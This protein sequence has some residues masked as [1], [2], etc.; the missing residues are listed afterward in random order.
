M[1]GISLKMALVVTVPVIVG[2]IIRKFLDNFISSKV[3][4]INKINAVLFLIVFAAIWIEE[5]ENIITYLSQAGLIVL[6]L[7]VVMMFIAYY[8]AKTFASG[9]EQRKCIAL[10]CGLQNGTLAVFVATQIFNDIIYMIP[11]AAYAL[12]MY[13]T[14]FIFLFIVRRSLSLI[15]I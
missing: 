11:T 13:I 8:L 12:I 9:I 6:I 4:V 2:I 14:A 1:T 7:N 5:R 10:E 3:S 15:H